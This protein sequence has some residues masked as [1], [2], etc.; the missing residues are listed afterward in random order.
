M[1]CVTAAPRGRFHALRRTVLLGSAAT[2]L[3]AIA[4]PALAQTPG[5]DRVVNTV[6][7]TIAANS[8]FGAGNDLYANRG[9]IKFAK[10]AAP[11]N[12]SF[13]NLEAFTNEG[14]LIDLRNERA[15]D[16]LTLSGGYAAS[17]NARLALDIGPTAVDRLIVQGAATGKTSIILRAAR[18]DDATLMAAPV[19]L[20][21][22]GAGST[23][24][25]FALSNRDLGL[26]RYNLTYDSTARAYQ[27]DASAGRAVHQS[28]RA[29]EGLTAAWR[30][31]ADAF[32]AEQALARAA[33]GDTARIWAQAHGAMID[34]DG[35]ANA[36]FRLGYEQQTFGLQTGVSLGAHPLLGGEAA[37]GLTG[38]N[39]QSTLD[40]DEGGAHVDMTTINGG[41]YGAW[42]RGN[43]F[44]TGLV[45]IDQHDLEILDRAAG[46]QGDLEGVTWGGQGSV[47]YRW[48][49]GGIAF[50]PT[51]GLE[52]LS[53]TLDDLEVLGQ[54]ISFDDHQG[55][56]ARFGAQ[57]MARIAL[58]DGGAVTW[59]AGL[60]AVHDFDVERI[61]TLHSN[62][63][64]DEVRVEGPQSYRRAQIGLQFETPGGLE[65]YVQGEAL[66]G[67]SDSGGGVRIGARYRF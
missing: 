36:A 53:S 6:E 32:G 57:A 18:P 45:K 9:T 47:G 3:A 46:F 50:E 2:T 13:L 60:E 42:R 65:T 44:A 25:A 7:L 23:A 52:Y 48:A 62:G 24:G 12:L 67:E 56:A 1:F 63:Q 27:L 5:D 22:V 17:G 21:T 26:V 39:V 41:A 55:L 61:G 37:F 29:G 30:A 33:G 20:V 28:V 19:T 51:V 54:S 11:L 64:S 15:G 40:F 38:G 66:F 59:S 14:G 10:A 31:S 8:D 16:T 58:V 4:A 49:F 34:R 35:Q 43:L